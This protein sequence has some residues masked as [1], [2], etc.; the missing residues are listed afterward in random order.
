MQATRDDVAGLLAILNDAIEH[1]TSSWQ[2]EP[3]TLDQ[4]LGWFDAKRTEGWPVLVAVAD[5]GSVAGWATFGSFR[6]WAG[7]RFTVEH[8]VYVHA[9]HRRRGIASRL[10]MA[11]I[12]EARQRGMHTMIGGASAENE[13]SIVLHEKLGFER[14]AILREVGTKFGRRLDLV[15]LQLLLD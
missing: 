7:Y 10:L 8:S 15:F 11:L 3:R 13:G 9:D 4:Q 14:V 12:A 2:D 6:P 5:D 1:T